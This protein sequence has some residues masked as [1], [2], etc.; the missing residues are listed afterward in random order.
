V[1]YKS[2][3]PVSDVGKFNVARGKVEVKASDEEKVE[4]RFD[5]RLVMMVGNERCPCLV[6]L[7][8]QQG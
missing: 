3:L 8:W 6:G 1:S 7:E 2:F 5:E 4:I